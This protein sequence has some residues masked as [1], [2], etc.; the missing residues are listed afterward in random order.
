[1]SSVRPSHVDYPSDREIVLSRVLAAPR[2]LVW[3]AITDPQRVTQW[4]GPRGFTSTT[5][6]H[7]FR[8]GGIWKH[9]MVGPDGVRYPNQSTFQEIVPLERIVYRHGGRREDG[10]GTTFVATWTFEPA[11]PRRTRVTMKLH[12]PSADARE[13]VVRE[14]G[15][16]EGGKQTLAR[17][18]EH[19]AAMPAVDQH[20]P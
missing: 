20:S 14:F 5:E 16:V 1:M 11:G 4:W 10:P 8:V 9:V 13:L 15:A 18:A 19:L 17:L 2:E 7:D 3:Q 12:F 6:I